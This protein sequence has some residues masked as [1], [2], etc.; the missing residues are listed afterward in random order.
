MPI[1]ADGS[2]PICC[3]VYDGEFTVSQSFLEEDVNEIQKRREQFF[4]WNMCQRGSPCI[5][6]SWPPWRPHK[7]FAVER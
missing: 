4:L 2:V 6:L 7:S 5:V 1:R 3:G